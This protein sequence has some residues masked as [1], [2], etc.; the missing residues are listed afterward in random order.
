MPVLLTIFVTLIA[1]G[2]LALTIVYIAYYRMRRQKLGCETVIAE[3][4]KRI[5]ALGADTNLTPPNRP[6]KGAID[7]VGEFDRVIA[8]LGIER[9]DS[10]RLRTNPDG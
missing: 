5:V 6:A 2:A 4:E 3:L 8:H 1:L 10:R 9:S 7:I